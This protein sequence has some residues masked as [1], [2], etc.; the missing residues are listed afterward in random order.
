MDGKWELFFYAYCIYMY[1]YSWQVE[2]GAVIYSENFENLCNL[3]VIV[4]SFGISRSPYV[5]LESQG[6][7]T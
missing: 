4:R 2:G 1:V 7:L 5:V 3:K 6:H